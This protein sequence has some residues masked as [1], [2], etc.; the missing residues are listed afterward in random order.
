MNTLPV[1]T[2]DGPAGVGKSTIARLTATILK[3]PYLDTGAMFRTVALL[4][5]PNAEQLP[6]QELLE[7]RSH[8]H[9]QLE[10]TGENTIL[11]C[12]ES[13]IGQE[14][15]TE[16]VGQ[17]ASRLA[18]ISAIRDWLKGIQRALAEAT[19][20]VAEGR[21][22]G[23]VIFPTA[24]FKFFLDASPEVRA[25]R[26]FNELHTKGEADL[27]HI[28]ALIRQRDQQ[29][30]NRPIAPL[31]PAQDAVIIDTSH[32][33]ITSVLAAILHVVGSPADAIPAAIHNPAA[34]TLRLAQK[35]DTQC[36]PTPKLT[37]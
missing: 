4:L 22:M 9:F 25:Q 11:K 32:M 17:L 5:G 13:I 27:T 21:D 24:R 29:D 18:T 12:N 14:I 16:Q 26:R 2:L 37:L 1:I 23:T 31:R 10:G 36:S 7:R 28:T 30:R 20:L 34:S 15:R 3:M 33:D 19:P 35:T 6:A 8:I